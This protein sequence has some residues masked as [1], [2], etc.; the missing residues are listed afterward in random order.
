MHT[1]IQINGLK[2][3]TFGDSKW[4]HPYHCQQRDTFIKLL[5]QHSRHSSCSFSNAAQWAL[6]IVITFLSHFIDK[7]TNSCLILWSN[8]QRPKRRVTLFFPHDEHC[9]LTKTDICFC[10]SALFFPSRFN[11]MTTDIGFLAPGHYGLT[12]A[13]EIGTKGL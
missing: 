3:K 7:A 6:S 8:H 13:L 9:F 12:L 11:R 5:N 2:N 4:S 10:I 1:H